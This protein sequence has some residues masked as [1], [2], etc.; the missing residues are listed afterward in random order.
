MES[1]RVGFMESHGRSS[2][3]RVAPRTCVMLTPAQPP[4]L[5]RVDPQSIYGLLRS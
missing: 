4:F 1:R 3:A 5:S 2:A